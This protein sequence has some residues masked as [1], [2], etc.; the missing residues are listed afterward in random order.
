VKNLLPYS[1]LVLLAANTLLSL[2]ILLFHA[3]GYRRIL[4]KIDALCDYLNVELFTSVG[5][6]EKYKVVKRKKAEENAEK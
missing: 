3:G 5:F 4:A 6:P 2:R 1:I